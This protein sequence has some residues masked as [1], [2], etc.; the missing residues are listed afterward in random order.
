MKNLKMTDLVTREKK[1]EIAK[2]LTVGLAD[3]WIKVNSKLI[4][5]LELEFT[6]WQ[7]KSE[8]SQVAIKVSLTAFL[9]F[10]IKQLLININHLEKRANE[11]NRHYLRA[12]DNEESQDHILAFSADLGADKSQLQGD[13]QA[14][15]R[16]FDRD[17]ILDRYQHILA[18]EQKKLSF[19]LERTGWIYTEAI[20]QSNDYESFWQRHPLE[21]IL[22]PL[23][24]FAGDSRVR[25]AAFNCLTRVLQSLPKEQTALLVGDSTLQYIYRASLERSQDVEIQKR[26]ISLLGRISLDSFAIVLKN[27][28]ETISGGDDFF[29]R[30]HVV[31]MLGKFSTVIPDLI[32]LISFAKNDPSAA[33]RQIIAKNLYGYPRQQSMDIF[34]HLLI[35]DQDTAVRASSALEIITF[36]QR[37]ECFS[38][39][40]ALLLDALESEK[41]SFVLRVLLKVSVDGFAGLTGENKKLWFK[42]L[43]PAIKSL[44]QTA[45]D[46]KTQ[47]YAAESAEWFWLYR[48]SRLTNLY[49]D[50]ASVLSRISESGRVKLSSNFAQL[51][52]SELARLLSLLAQDNYGLSLENNIWGRFIRKGDVFKFRFWRFIYELRNASTDKRQAHRHTIGRHFFGR[53]RAPSNIMCELAETKVPGEPLLIDNELSGRTFLPLVDDMLSALDQGWLKQPYTIVTSDGFTEIT[54]PKSLL[55]RM[56]AQYKLTFRFS[57]YARIRNQ[58]AT[59]NKDAQEYILSLEKLGFKIVF[60]PHGFNQLDNK[61]EKSGSQILVN[62]KAL[63]LWPQR[64][65]PAL[66]PFNLSQYTEQAKDYFFSVYENTLLHLGVFVVLVSSYFF[67]RHVVLN[68][69][70]RKARKAI[71][72]VIGGWGTR[73][74]S[75]TERLKAAL[76]S[77]LGYSVVSKTSGCEAM[78][79]HSQPFGTLREMFLFRPYDKATIWEQVNVVRLSADLECDVFLWE[80]MGLTP[81]YVHV[82]QKDWMQDDIATITN[83]Y[84]DH[85][86]LQGPAGHEIPRVMTNFIPKSS[87]LI[88]TEEQMLPILKQSAEQ[89]NS[90]ISSVGWLQAGLL[91]ED[92]LLRFPYEEHPYNIALV[93]ELAKEIDIDPDFAVKEMADKVVADLGVLKTYPVS[94]VS[95][96]KL[97]FVM[98][99]SANEKFGCIGNWTRMEFDKHCL[100]KDPETWV[101][102]VVNNRADRV[103]RSK[104]FAG[105][106]A[107]DISADRHILIGDNLHGLLGFIREAWDENLS[108]LNLFNPQETELKKYDAAISRLKQ[109]A[110]K[111]RVPIN[112]SQIKSRFFAMLDGLDAQD[113]LELSSQELDIERLKEYWKKPNELKSILNKFT[114]KNEE[115]FMLTEEIVLF[116]NGLHQNYQEYQ[117]LL[118]QL[119]K[120]EDVDELQASYQSLVWSWFEKK[121]IV[122]ENYHASGNDVINEIVK[123][124]PPG[125]K[126]RIMGMQNIKGTGLDYVYRWQAWESCFVACEQMLS[127]DDNMATAGVKTLAKFKDYGLLCEN[128]V[129]ET[130]I[131][132]KDRNWTQTEAIQAELALIL[133]NLELAMQAENKKFQVSAGEGADAGVISK[134]IAEYLEA[135]LDAGDA[136]KR[137]KRANQIYKDL[138]NKRISHQRASLELQIIN[139]RQKGGWAGEYITQFRA[140]NS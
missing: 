51:K 65:F 1:S 48:Q 92:V 32:S 95:G 33:V 36:I 54:V 114:S 2:L 98:G 121:L 84:P 69:K 118:K 109:S 55:K 29:V 97:E 135:F 12:S 131:K 42:I 119:E 63:A 124:T 67:G 122:V 38:D 77:G 58:Q 104:V 93:L 43:L 80:C 75:G 86:D 15:S 129:R 23:F 107:K 132:M 125:L 100:D 128:K 101:T 82:L 70:M 39:M 27:R 24:V 17:A 139:K 61:N 108:M 112:E 76:F 22:R 123:N 21:E 6:K 89:F 111:L 47:Q 3:T 46:N 4:L 106:I 68:R 79:L 126:A 136:V 115:P 64:F 99:M 83:T 73:G 134:K 81:S 140:D 52:D 28:L 133:S 49:H 130:I 26:A 60:R 105:I 8:E 66:L 25:T 5:A 30:R 127:D 50:L 74:K 87:K 103:P 7:K 56:R 90:K 20:S 31:T 102:T 9:L 110:L 117:S 45:A 53:L 116:L 85:E 35:D 13:K 37:P 137:R 19:C 40:T 88:T 94:K 113:G 14:F 34:K 41:N 18:S 96:R 57:D 72:L 71:P 62:E 78:F 91:T 11:F 10:E 59:N 44:Q 120:G 138:A 16:W